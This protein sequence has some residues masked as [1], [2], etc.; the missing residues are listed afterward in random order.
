MSE[1]IPT[2]LFDTS[3]LMH[4][5]LGVAANEK[6]TIQWGEVK[7]EVDVLRSIRKPKKSGNQDWSL[8]SE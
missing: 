6:Q 8:N 4:G 3:V 5:I 1:N 2:V 7:Q